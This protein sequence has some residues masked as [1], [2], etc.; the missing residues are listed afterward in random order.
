VNVEPVDRLAR[1]SSPDRLR[2]EI[3]DEG[4]DEA[5]AGF[6][7]LIDFRLAFRQN[8][9]DTLPER[10]EPLP[11]HADHR[12]TQ[13]HGAVGG[14]LR[15]MLPEKARRETAGATPEL[16]DGLRAG[17]VTE[18]DQFVGGA[19]LVEGLRVQLLANEV[20]DPPRLG[21]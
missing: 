21:V 20:V 14:L 1:H 13:V 18:A 2:K 10:R 15:E 11:G 9:L 16:E 7:R 19:I 12:A 4:A 5:I 17:E 8:D 6:R 3:E